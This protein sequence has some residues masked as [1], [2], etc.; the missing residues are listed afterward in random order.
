MGK[1]GGEEE[2]G[3]EEDIERGEGGSER[4]E[5]DEEEIER[6]EG[7]EEEPLQDG[8]VCERIAENKISSP[9][10]QEIGSGQSPRERRRIDP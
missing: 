5:S 1:L 3:E 7:E 6:G 9:A 4:E 8:N 2:K 10:T